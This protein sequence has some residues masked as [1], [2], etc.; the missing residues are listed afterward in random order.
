MRSKVHL[1]VAALGVV[2]CAKSERAQEPVAAPVQASAAPTPPGAPTPK[3]EPES[4]AS[5]VAPTP[6][7]AAAD[8]KPGLG[9]DQGGAQKEIASLPEAEQALANAQKELDTL[10][11][12]L[13]RGGLSKGGASALSSGDTRCPNACKAMGSLRH[14][15]DAICRLTSPSD[16]RCAH[17]KDVVASSEKRVSACSCP[18]P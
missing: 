6:P 16:K 7:P 10:V 5:A 17:A 14:A 1:F 3:S 18:A 13:A 4:A 12:P 11:G 9:L 8:D 15:A 2:A